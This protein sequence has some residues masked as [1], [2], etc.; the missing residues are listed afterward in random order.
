MDFRL[1]A[2]IHD[3][4]LFSYRSNRRDLAIK[5]RECM[6]H[7]MTIKDW[8]GIARTFTIPVALK[9]EAKYWN[10]LKEME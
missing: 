2:Q 3:S 9:G 1:H 10:E 6:T 7:P 4:V 5:V 8:K